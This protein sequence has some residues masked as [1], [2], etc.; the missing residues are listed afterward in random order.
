MLSNAVQ[1]KE[2]QIVMGGS[3]FDL[4]HPEIGVKVIEGLKE[5]IGSGN[6]LDHF[7][8]QSNLEFNRIKVN[9]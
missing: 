2:E 4:I 6:Y 8:R 7:G 9:K 3:N 5:K 1:R